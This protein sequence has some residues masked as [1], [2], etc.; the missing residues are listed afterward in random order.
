VRPRNENKEFMVV[1]QRLGQVIFDRLVFNRTEAWF[2][3]VLEGSIGAIT[4]WCNPVLPFIGQPLFSPHP[5]RLDNPL[6]GVIDWSLD[7]LGCLQDI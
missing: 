1:K 6:I 5:V 4:T 7:H 2:L 3:H